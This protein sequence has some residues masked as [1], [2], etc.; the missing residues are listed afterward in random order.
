[1]SSNF[2]DVGD[3]HAKFD[4]PNVTHEGPYPRQPDPKL[5]EFRL[6]FLLEELG[7]LIE[8]VGAKLELSDIVVAGSRSLLAV[9]PEDAE[10]DHAKAFDALLDLAY[11]T[12]GAAHVLGYPWQ[13]GWDRVQAANIT[14][15]RSI[16]T[17][18]DRVA[19]RGGT[20]DVIKPPG[21]TP[22]DIEGLLRER[23]WDTPE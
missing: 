12:F 7:E 9:V 16:D 5:M 2:D 6:N 23:G 18:P 10:I 19:Q 21:W 1:M 13:E 17:S 20:W 15:E 22:P 4:L 11:V 8:A 3:F 14:K